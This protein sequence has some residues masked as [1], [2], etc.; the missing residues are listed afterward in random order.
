MNIL[1]EQSVNKRAHTHTHTAC[2]AICG[3]TARQLGCFEIENYGTVISHQT[4]AAFKALANTIT[5]TYQ[6]IL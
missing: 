4:E 6:C 1:Q 3:K 5:N 2:C